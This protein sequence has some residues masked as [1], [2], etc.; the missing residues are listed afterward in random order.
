MYK[1]DFKNY[2]SDID[3]AHVWTAVILAVEGED[4]GLVSPDEEGGGE[5]LG[6][7]VQPGQVERGG[8]VASPWQG[9]SHEDHLRLGAVLLQQLCQTQLSVGFLLVLQQLL[10]SDGSLRKGGEDTL[11][12]RSGL[13]PGSLGDVRD[14]HD[15]AELD[16]EL[17]QQG[18]HVPGL[19]VQ[20]V[21]PVGEGEDP[22]LGVGELLPGGEDV[23][24]EQGET[25]VIIEPPHVDGAASLYRLEKAQCNVEC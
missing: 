8:D 7:H 6:G 12:G 2:N 22:Q 19:P 9:E 3:V 13:L 16:P 21:L 17:G 14:H 4:T 11:E 18:R 24:Q 10:L 20:L 25:P 23:G 5:V 1:L 15:A